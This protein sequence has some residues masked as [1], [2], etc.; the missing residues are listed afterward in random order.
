[1]SEQPPFVPEEERERS[2]ERLAKHNL[3]L[4]DE[5]ATILARIKTSEGGN[6]TIQKAREFGVSERELKEYAFRFLEKDIREGYSPSVV[7]SIAEQSG[8]VTEAEVN[9]LCER[10]KAEMAVAV[11]VVESDEDRVL[12]EAA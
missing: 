3:E 7:R 1:M 8:V 4:A 5:M 6:P 12:R 9:E 2:A 11:P 10:I